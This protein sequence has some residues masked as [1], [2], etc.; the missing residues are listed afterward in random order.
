MSDAA[1]I[2]GRW[3]EAEVA[4]LF[5]RL[6]A[7][8]FRNT[9]PMDGSDDLWCEPM[10][11]SVLARLGLRGPVQV[12]AKS[13]STFRR[14]KWLDDPRWGGDGHHGPPR[15]EHGFELTRAATYWRR[16]IR[17]FV[18]VERQRELKP[19]HLVESHQVLLCDP[20][21]CE[22]RRGGCAPKPG[23]AKVAFVYF[24]RQL[25]QH[26]GDTTLNNGILTFHPRFDR[27]P[28]GCK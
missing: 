24:D 11:G 1:E 26:I 21:Q 2:L 13:A 6:D 9:D 10:P 28:G 5:R 19:G 20:A 17:Q 22:P 27:V 3:G 16:G 23:A 7:R 18:F 4:E 25:M 8:V 14:T 12:K 15:E